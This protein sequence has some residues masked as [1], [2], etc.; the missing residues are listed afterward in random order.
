LKIRESDGALAESGET[1]KI[2]SVK[3]S[4]LAE[5]DYANLGFGDYFS[6]HMVTCEFSGGMWGEPSI[7][8]FSPI[9]MSPAALALHYGQ[10]VFEGLKA[11]R[12]TD[13]RKIRL[14]RVDRNAARLTASCTRLCIPA[15]DESLVIDSIKQ[16]VMLDQGWAPSR[17][18]EALYVRPVLIATEPHLAVRPASRYRLLI[19]TSPVC[20]YFA[21]V[22]SPLYL[23]AEER[24]TR[25]PHGG[26]GYAKTASN[27]SVTLRPMNDSVE[28][29]FDQILWL[30]GQEH[31]YVEEA[32]QMN[33][34]FR[35]GDS[36][37]TP[38]LS[39]T[40][41]P[42]VTRESVL[43][44]LDDMGVTATE[45][46]LSMD[47]LFLAQANGELYEA[48]GAGTASVVVPIGRIRYHD[49]DLRFPDEQQGNLC[50]ELYNK[51]LGIQHGELEDRHYWM[52]PLE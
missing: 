21:Q 11:F 41:L 19:F 6:D 52:M 22:K 18:G 33:I 1:M 38:D 16:L 26:T 15:P 40:I 12:G 14:F 23:K 42:G 45:R 28:D 34:F 20:E 8:P 49:S 44:L 10:T 48:F 32:G 30:D 47:E 3:K 17:R 35:L 51:I 39:G 9:E 43:T 37:V 2:E 5:V 24:Y 25:A 4:R 46:R 27:Y 7:V 13:D 36:V 50:P 29:G 31:K